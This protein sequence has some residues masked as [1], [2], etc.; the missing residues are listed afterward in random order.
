MTLRHRPSREPPQLVLQTLASSST[1]SG[2]V[3]RSDVRCAHITTDEVCGNCPAAVGTTVMRSE[4]SG[5]ILCLT[6]RHWRTTP[7]GIARRIPVHTEYLHSCREITLSYRKISCA[8]RKANHRLV[9]NAQH[10]TS[11]RSGET[12]SR[13]PPLRRTVSGR[14]PRKPT[15]WHALE[16]RRTE[17]QP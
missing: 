8:H 17:H 1:Q 9:H 7:Y 15:T 4:T 6:A 5:N 13:V 12:G 16:A 11:A 3:V 14:R 10:T 2:Q